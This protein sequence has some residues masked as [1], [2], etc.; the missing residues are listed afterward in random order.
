M[1]LISKDNLLKMNYDRK[2]ARRSKKN[3]RNKKIMRFQRINFNSLIV[4][5]KE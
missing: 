2:H 4:N 3:Y 5:S 1:T